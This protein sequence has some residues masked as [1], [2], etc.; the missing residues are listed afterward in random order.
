MASEA[1]SIAELTISFGLVTIPVRLFSATVTSEKISFNLLH[2]KDKS[3]VKQQYICALDGE[4]VPRDEMVKGYEFAKGEYVIFTPEEIKAL[5]EVGSDAIN[6]EDFV[7]LESVDPMF[8]DKTYYLTPGKKAN[9]PYALLRTT[10]AESKRCAVGRWAARGREHIVIVRPVGKGLAMHQLHFQAEVRSIDDF[11][12]ESETLKEAEIK[13]ARQLVDQQSSKA[14][15]PT[16]YVDEVRKRVDKAIE[17]KIR[18]GGQVSL[19]HERVADSDNVIDIM[20]ALRASLKARSPASV[21][22]RKPPKRVD[23]ATTAAK[24]RASK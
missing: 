3:R 9:R 24:S 16:Q 10:L 20:E 19:K 15:D 2:A 21:A 6:I 12:I 5:E 1:R 22:Q 7:P 18:K 4:I 17:Q 8:F 23:K 13:L 14:F 11:A